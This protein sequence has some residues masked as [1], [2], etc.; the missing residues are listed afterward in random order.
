MGTR[1]AELVPPEDFRAEFARLAPRLA[2]LEKAQ[3]DD[4]ALDATKVASKV[5]DLINSMCLVKRTDSR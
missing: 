2:G 4:S 5:W 1:G 3:I